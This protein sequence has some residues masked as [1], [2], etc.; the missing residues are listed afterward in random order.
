MLT[1]QLPF[2]QQQFHGQGGLNQPPFPQY[3]PTATLPLRPLQPPSR[4]LGLPAYFP[5]VPHH[6]MQ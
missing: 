6:F 1:M 2:T 3:Q 4:Q 5:Q